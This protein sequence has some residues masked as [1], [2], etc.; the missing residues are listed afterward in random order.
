MT[1]KQFSGLK[2]FNTKFTNSL[3]SLLLLQDESIQGSETKSA[4]EVRYETACARLA[5]EA[6]LRLSAD[7]VTVLVLAI[8]KNCAS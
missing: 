2:R 4:E 8:S 5:N 7:N 1:Q 3:F 6:V